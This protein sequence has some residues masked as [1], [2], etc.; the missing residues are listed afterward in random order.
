MKKDFYIDY[1]DIIALAQFD[2]VK[3]IARQQAGGKIKDLDALKMF[4]HNN[5]YE[6][7]ETILFGSEEARD[8]I[9]DFIKFYNKEFVEKK[10]G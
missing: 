9:S 1:K 10:T 7:F 4:L 6:Y 3:L 8:I 5:G 2:I